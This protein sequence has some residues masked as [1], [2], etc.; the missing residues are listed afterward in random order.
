MYL[1]P[2]FMVLFP[3]NTFLIEV[4]FNIPLGSSPLNSWKSL[5]LITVSAV[6]CSSDV[7][8]LSGLGKHPIYDLLVNG[9]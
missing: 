3:N 6:D 5:A 4:V 9:L 7:T 2:G 1:S 8:F